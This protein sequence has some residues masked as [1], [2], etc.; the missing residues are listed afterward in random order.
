MNVACLRR[1]ARIL[2]LEIVKARVGKCPEGRIWEVL[3]RL[4]EELL[5]A[6]RERE[7]IFDRARDLH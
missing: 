1:R 6:E 5:W 4:I 7:A 3:E 2:L